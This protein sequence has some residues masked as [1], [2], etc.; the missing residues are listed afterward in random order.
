MVREFCRVD[1]GGQC[2]ILLPNGGSTMKRWMK[3]AILSLMLAQ[4]P[5]VQA[6]TLTLPA[7]LQVI[8]ANAFEGAAHTENVVV[9][10]GTLE[11]RSR[12]FADS[13]LQSLSLPESLVFIAD[14]ALEGCES[15]AVTAPEGT[16]AYAWAVECGYADAPYEVACDRTQA[17]TG[18]VAT[19]TVTLPE[20]MAL[21]SVETELLCGDEAVQSGEGN[22]LS[23]MLTCG[24]DYRLRVSVTDGAG[25]TL[26][27]T[28]ELLP[29]SERAAAP[30]AA[31]VYTE[32]GGEI[33]ITDYIGTDPVVIVPDEIEGKPVRS[34]A[35]QP[36][37]LVT[38]VLLPETMVEF[39]SN[40]AF[41][42]L[43]KL[44]AVYIPAGV[45]EIPDSTFCDCGEL[46][47]VF[48]GENVTRIGSA[49]FA[50]CVKLQLLQMGEKV[51]F[52]GQQAFEYCEKLPAIRLS[53]ATEGIGE[54]AFYH[55]LSLES[56]TFVGEAADNDATIGIRAFGWCPIA[57]IE[58]PEG[59]AW[60]KSYAFIDC[61]NLTNVILPETLST[62]SVY[63]FDDGPVFSVI[64]GS[65]AHDWCIEQEKEF[66]I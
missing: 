43:E 4:I 57:S 20:E 45:T 65:Y 51:T 32:E 24:G 49:A 14:D 10:E 39:N 16:Y 56:V 25:Y 54:N 41:Y 37:R 6:E 30:A 3:I 42:A 55:C 64:D 1:E 8:D 15:V 34:A 40:T 28:S 47:Y 61:D 52:V 23:A 17:Q 19:W 35:F 46:A 12:A 48:G 11:I 26:R 7:D 13:G 53:R 2:A 59:V 63:A 18:D 33:R 29:V 66:I 27:T 36:D 50:D 60:I 22:S 58:I 31:F 21:W 9:P 44:Q 38:H 62:I 5:C